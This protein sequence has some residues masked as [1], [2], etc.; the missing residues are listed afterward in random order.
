MLIFPLINDTSRKIIHVDMDAFF[1]SIEERDN[2]ELIGKPVVIARNPIETGGRG[3]VSTA[4]YVARK[5]GIHSAMS[6]KEAYELCPQAVFVSGN[7]EHYREISRQMHEIFH[8]Y[9]DQVEGM[10]LDEAY[11]DV[12]E[13]KIGATSAV[14]IAKMIQHDIFTEL[15]LT[16]SAGVSYNKFLAKIA[17][18]IEKPRGLTLITPEKALDFLANLPVEEFHGVGAK[19]AE[20]LEVLGIKTGKEIQAY[21]PQILAEK[22]GIFGWELYLKANGIHNSPVKPNRLRK[23]VGKEKTYGKLLYLAE[24]IKAEIT[25]LSQKVSDILGENKLQGSIIVIKIRYADFATMTKRVSLDEK[26]ADFETIAQQA[27]KL[28]ENSLRENAGVRL[29]G[30]TVTGL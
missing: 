30:V 18:D 27:R 7:Y 10:A 6:S 2:P 5:F 19:T 20:K 12:T 15:H 3:V 26:T 4:N 9:T 28:L 11:L 23:S 8:R 21:S 1:A 24:D 16:S 22:L 29:L 13:N 17:S 14:K 25:I